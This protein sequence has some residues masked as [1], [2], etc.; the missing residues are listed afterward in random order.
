MLPDEK[1]IEILGDMGDMGIFGR[2]GWIL[3]R[4]KLGRWRKRV[5]CKGGRGDNDELEARN[6]MTTIQTV[7][8]T[9]ARGTVA[10][11]RKRHVVEWAQFRLR[12]QQK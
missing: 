11:Q 3:M 12:H 10:A 1:R 2:K 6:E 5:G 9:S 8:P 4:G 7:Q